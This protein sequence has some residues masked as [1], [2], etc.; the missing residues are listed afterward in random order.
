MDK[1]SN[2]HFGFNRVGNISGND[3]F[4]WSI[5]RYQHSFVKQLQ[6]AIEKKERRVKSAFQIKFLKNTCGMF[7]SR[8]FIL[9]RQLPFPPK[10]LYSFSRQQEAFYKEE[11]YRLNF[12]TDLT[13]KVRILAECKYHS[14]KT[15]FPHMLNNYD[16]IIQLKLPSLICLIITTISFN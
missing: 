4:L 3:G 15:A 8:R 10:K 11:Q 12:K 9:E 6:A 7:F 13:L 2:K 1:F 14:I 16:N 5:I